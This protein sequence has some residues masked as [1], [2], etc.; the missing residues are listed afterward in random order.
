MKKFLSAIFCL[1]ML[2]LN[3]FGAGFT[4]TQ[5]IK[6]GS[7]ELKP[8]AYKFEVKGEKVVFKEGKNVVA[9]VP[10]TTETAPK[11][12][13]DTTYESANGQIT[14]IR[15]GGTTTRLVLK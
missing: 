7:I 11:K 4:V 13:A 15:V 10:V 6:A 2:A 8:G 14:A 12:Y 3:A 9:E 1:S 5:P